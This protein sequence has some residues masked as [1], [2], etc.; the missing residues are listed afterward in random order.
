M[1]DLHPENPQF[2]NFPEEFKEDE[3]VSIRIKRTIHLLYTCKSQARTLYLLAKFKNNSHTQ[4]QT[5]IRAQ[6]VTSG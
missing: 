5:Q 1:I 4:A 2:F 3:T 6:M